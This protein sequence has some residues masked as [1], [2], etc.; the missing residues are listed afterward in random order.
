MKTILRSYTINTVSLYIVSTIASGIVFDQGVK[1]LLL[2]GIGLMISSLIL[3]PIIN[4]LLLPINLITFGLFRWLSSAITIYL[5]TL[6]IHG[7]RIEKFYF[8]GL[9]TNLID[10]PA[11]SL[12]GIWSF[13]AFSLALSVVTSTIHWLFK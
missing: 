6:L 4:I 5:V 11:L 7:F 2:A 12:G 1:T 3:K 8:A 10:L 13:V 9:H